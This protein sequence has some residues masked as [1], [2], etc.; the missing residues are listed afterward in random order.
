MPASDDFWPELNGLRPMRDSWSSAVSF[1]R[2]LKALYADLS[3][4]FVNSGDPSAAGWAFAS[5]LIM[6][7]PTLV[8]CATRLVLSLPR[9]PDEVSR[10]GASNPSGFGVA[11]QPVTL[12]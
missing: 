8:L 2:F 1:Q 9:Q 11:R 6:L 10:Q 12:T 3:S 4:S 5:S 7:S